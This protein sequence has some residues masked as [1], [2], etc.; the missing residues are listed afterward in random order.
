MLPWRNSADLACVRDLGG[1]ILAVNPAF[2]RKFGLAAERLIGTAV[3]ELIHPDDVADWNEA[4]RE[5]SRPPHRC[6]S[7]QRWHTA[8][9]WRWIEWES[10]ALFDAER[11]FIAIRSVGRDVSKRR[12]AEEQSFRLA[13]ATEQSPISVVITDPTGRVQYVNPKFTGVT[14][15]TLEDI[16]DRNVDVLRAGHPTDD[17]YGA[18]RQTVHEGR[19]WRG[20]LRTTTKDGRVIWESVQVS[21]LRGPTGEVINLLSLREDITGRRSLEEQLRQSQKMESLGTLAGGIAHDFNNLLA[22]VQGYA[23]AGLMRESGD[24]RLRNFLREIHTAARRA[25]GL[26]RQILTFSRKTEIQLGPV[27]LNTIVRRNSGQLIS[28]TPSPARF[29]SISISITRCRRCGATRT[30]STRWCSICA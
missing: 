21:P 23:E 4:F 22:I 10:A 25:T 20:E 13:R 26:V 2:A 3:G 7:E 18:F 12:M 17:S 6:R 28:R 1:G 11:Q 27:D 16:L 5:T 14:G 8:L 15:F 24:E 19:E 29:R 9:G 30:S